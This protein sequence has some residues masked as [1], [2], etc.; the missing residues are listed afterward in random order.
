MSTRGGYS[1]RR[2]QNA[3]RIEQTGGKVTYVERRII[4][5]IREATEASEEDIEITLKECGGDVNEATEKLIESP[6][7]VVTKRKKDDRKRPERGPV[8]PANASAR[9]VEAGGSRG[10]RSTRDGRGG[11]SGAQNGQRAERSRGGGRGGG[12][13]KTGGRQ[14]TG[15][16]RKGQEPPYANGV[17]EKEAE[18]Q[19]VA[20]GSGTPE[21]TGATSAAAQPVAPA[22]PRKT[23]YADALCRGIGLS[24]P[25]RTPPTGPPSGS[26]P[27]PSFPSGAA[28]PPMDSPAVTSTPEATASEP[29]APPHPITTTTTTQPEVPRDP[30][31]PAVEEDEPPSPEPVEAPQPAVDTTIPAQSLAEPP[32]PSVPEG[33]GEVQAMESRFGQMLTAEELAVP[34]KGPNFDNL[35]AAPEEFVPE[36][37]PAYPA[38]TVD[39]SLENPPSFE[40]SGINLKF[41]S[42]AGVDDTGRG[43]EEAAAAQPIDYS[44]V[45]GDNVQLEIDQSEPA[46]SHAQLSVD[47]VV[48][49][50]IDAVPSD[51]FEDSQDLAED[52]FLTSVS[53]P[54]PERE[55]E[56]ILTPP[57]ETGM[58]NVGSLALPDV[59]AP[60]PPV[61]EVPIETKA[62]ASTQVVV[63]EPEPPKQIPEPSYTSTGVQHTSYNP[64][65]SM[66]PQGGAIPDYVK[67][68][69]K[70]SFQASQFAVELQ[71]QSNPERKQPQPPY[72]VEGQ[73]GAVHHQR[74]PRHQTVQDQRPFET[75]Q[76]TPNPSPSIPPYHRQDPPKQDQGPAHSAHAQQARLVGQVSAG[77]QTDANAA[78]LG[79]QAAQ[80]AA[81]AATPSSGAPSGVAM[82]PP[83]PFGNPM[84]PNP[85]IP[86][87]PHYYHTQYM[88][89]HQY[90]AMAYHG[91]Y[92]GTYSYNGAFSHGAESTGFPAPHV[93]PGATPQK[94]L[95]YNNPPGVGATSVN[96]G[97][98]QNYPANAGIY[99]LGGNT[100]Y[101][102]SGGMTGGYA[103]AKEKDNL[104]QP[105]Q[106]HSGYGP[107][108][109]QQVPRNDLYYVQ[110]QAYNGQGFR[111]QGYHHQGYGGQFGGGAYAGPPHTFHNVNAQQNGFGRM[112]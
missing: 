24:Q 17:H 20:S 99:A 31:P 96:Q 98:A 25:A 16:E 27:G 9:S 68:V 112:H 51:K 18:A 15:E 100:G 67:A 41:G 78:A 26:M 49:P 63:Q 13:I 90:G 95:P 105:G 30:T 22:V 10:A 28:R 103:Y 69:E 77:A 81:T 82:A 88:Q 12:A 65:A 4:D 32:I 76:H 50:Q 73:V 43:G 91:M 11:P 47:P 46:S 38:P 37:L 86:F 72:T 89:A 79:N 1:G 75:A 80:A 84:L 106:Q 94:Y 2:R 85:G 45:A 62:D 71:E 7:K 35:N 104:P 70:N 101:E 61:E 107:G 6:F 97:Y 93:P 108:I 23:G 48:E 39:L 52:M 34:I 53:A 55:P 33:W 64:A 19:E 56:Q 29:S 111:N 8:R 36:G 87:P 42:F 92:P 14:R 102:A 74:Q 44:V 54:P 21:R 110:G 40:L 57:I 3:L 58:D 59:Y 5:Q 109:G 83:V 66:T 60:Q